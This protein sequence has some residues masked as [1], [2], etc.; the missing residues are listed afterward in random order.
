MVVNG[1]AETGSTS[2]FTTTGGFAALAYGSPGGF[3]AAGDPGVALGG[4]Y[5]FYGGQTD[6]A[7]GSQVINLASDSAAIDSGAVAA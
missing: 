2:G 4:S 6:S 3:P 1:D 5:F 7:S